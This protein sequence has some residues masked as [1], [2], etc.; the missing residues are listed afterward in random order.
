MMP[1]IVRDATVEDAADILAIYNHAAV[2][3]TAVWTDGPSDLKSR[4]DWI[5]ARQQAGFPV[6][7]AMSGAHVVGFAS[8][9][10]FRPW[11]GYRHTVENSVYVD[12]RHHRLGIGRSLVSALIERAGVMNKHVMIAGIESANEAS[13]ALH[14][15]L[16]FAE[17]ARMPE[18]GCKF[19]RWL[20]LVLMQKQLAGE[21]R[22]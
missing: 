3:T 12:E 9:G 22:P 14:A 15:S 7:V 21:V 6:L 1:L 11:P 17:V 20:D 8:F 10:D 19:G 5:V 13:I 2:N 16:G 18:V 4:R